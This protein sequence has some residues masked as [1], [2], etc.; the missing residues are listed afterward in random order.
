MLFTLNVPLKAQFSV[1]PSQ[2]LDKFLDF[3]KQI[4]VYVYMHGCKYI[5]YILI[6]HIHTVLGVF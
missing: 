6:L 2:P 1:V 4:V 5:H 3:N